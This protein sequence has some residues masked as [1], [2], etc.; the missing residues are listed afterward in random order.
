M[1]KL[2][3]FDES[4]I[5]TRAEER[6]IACVETLHPQRLGHGNAQPHVRRHPAGLHREF[7]GRR[8]RRRGCRQPPGRCGG[9]RGERL[10]GRGDTRRS[11]AVHRQGRSRGRYR[12]GDLRERQSRAA[13]AAQA[14]E[15]APE[16]DQKYPK[17]RRSAAH[18]GRRSKSTTT[19]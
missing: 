6:T 3:E 7:R 11:Q 9:T 10:D 8:L 4:H 12:P 17:R 1:E 14:I 15:R 5:A 13:T 16:A 18:G 2:R 19:N